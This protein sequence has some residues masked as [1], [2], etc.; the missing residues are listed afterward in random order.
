MVFETMTENRCKTVCVTS[1]IESKAELADR[2]TLVPV[3]ESCP[4]LRLGFLDELDQCV[5]IQT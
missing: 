3:L 4:F 1:S 2:I 5:Y